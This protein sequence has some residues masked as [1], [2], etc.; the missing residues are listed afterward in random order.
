MKPRGDGSLS[1]VR[2][3]LA[4]PGDVGVT[5]ASAATPGPP[6][7]LRG[8]TH[9]GG[10]RSGGFD[11]RGGGVCGAASSVLPVVGSSHRR[12]SPLPS[13]P[14]D[15]RGA[16][17]APPPPRASTRDAAS[18]PPARSAARATT[19]ASASHDDDAAHGPL[20]A[21]EHASV[22]VFAPT[23]VDAHRSYRDE[24]D[25]ACSAASR[26]V[27]I[28]AAAATAGAHVECRPRCAAV[29]RGAAPVEWRSVPSGSGDRGAA[30]L[31]RGG[32]SGCASSR[33]RRPRRSPSTTSTSLGAPSKKS[34]DERLT[35]S[36]AG[37]P[38]AQGRPRRTGGGL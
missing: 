33:R 20:A 17:S 18:H 13:A 8:V 14:P 7:G 12:G 16:P 38:R 34:L 5:H 36:I 11:R 15:A 35:A 10:G 31:E 6:V 9:A 26:I 30:L 24:R 25:W 27:E 23:A 28:C 1:S 3:S 4:P 29:V 19:A 32:G 22:C 2:T 21:S 37:V